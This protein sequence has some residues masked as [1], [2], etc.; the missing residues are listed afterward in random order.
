MA[1]ITNKSYHLHTWKVHDMAFVSN[2]IWHGRLEYA[3]YSKSV[4]MS[5]GT[6]EDLVFRSKAECSDQCINCMLRKMKICDIPKSF[7]KNT[8]DWSPRHWAHWCV[9]SRSGYIKRRGPV[10]CAIHRQG[11]SNDR[12]VHYNS[13]TCRLCY[14]SAL[15]SYFWNGE[16]QNLLCIHGIRHVTTNAILT[17]RM[18]IQKEWFERC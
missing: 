4:S 7:S 17:N 16:I 10:L 12:G 14:I 11:I 18:G 2:E 5:K 3:G 1:T 15:S 6:A 8:K 13:E 9:R